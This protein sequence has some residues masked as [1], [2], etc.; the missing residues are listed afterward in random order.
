MLK[1]PGLFFW[2]RLTNSFKLGTVPNG[3]VKTLDRLTV[4]SGVWQARL[5][6]ARQGAAWHGVAGQAGRG[7]AWQG[8]ARHGM[9]RFG[10]NI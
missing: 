6:E 7:A 1:A 2:Y 3:S 9:A 5:G 8:K 4:P 10:R